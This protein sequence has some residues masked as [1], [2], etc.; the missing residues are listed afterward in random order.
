ME[1][2]IRIAEILHTV[3]CKSVHNMDCKY[4]DESLSS[5][6]WNE[7]HHKRWLLTAE[8]FI[9]MSGLDENTILNKI[10]NILEYIKL[11]SLTIE[12]NE[13]I[14]DFTKGVVKM[15]DIV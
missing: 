15:I 2:L 14:L 3:N 6:P 1:N 4:Y 9:K 13:M 8:G 11:I 10:Q 5:D 7:D 12:D